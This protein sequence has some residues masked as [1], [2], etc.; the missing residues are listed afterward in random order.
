MPR[1]THLGGAFV[2]TSTLVLWFF[3]MPGVYRM[4]AIE[5][6][7]SLFG[8]HLVVRLLKMVL[9]RLRPY[10]QLNH[11]HTFPNPLTDYSFPSGHTTAAFSIA[12]TFISHV[13]ILIIILLPYAILVGFSRMYLALHYPTDVL[14][15]FVIGTGFAIG[16][17]HI[18]EIL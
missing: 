18:F 9:P 14:I 10:L 7:V 12:T 4:W 6:M 15:G 17:T 3:L 5:G 13:P 2:T 1:F 16:T 8:S 11:L